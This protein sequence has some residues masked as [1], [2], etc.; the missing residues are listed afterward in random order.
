MIILLVHKL[1][2]QKRDLQGRSRQIPRKERRFA[3]DRGRMAELGSAEI[4]GPEPAIPRGKQC[5]AGGL[6]KLSLDEAAG[7]GVRKLY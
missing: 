5:L 4:G 7:C 6:T 3:V 2:L 1:Y